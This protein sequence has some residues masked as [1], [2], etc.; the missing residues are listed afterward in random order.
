MRNRYNAWVKANPG[1]L[2]T[3]I[4]TVSGG[5]DYVL[6]TV[7][8][9]MVARHDVYVKTNGH[10]PSVVYIMPQIV[11]P[12]L[13]LD[14]QTLLQGQINNLTDYYTLIQKHGVYNH[15]DCLV[16]KD[17]NVAMSKIRTSGLN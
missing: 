11:K 15:Y 2:P 12:K 5:S 13:I 9:D 4:Y 10:E 1:Q 16:N 7:F 14:L 6:L 3:K 17:P 8:D